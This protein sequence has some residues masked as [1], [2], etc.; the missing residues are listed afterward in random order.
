MQEF[1]GGSAVKFQFGLCPSPEVEAERPV[2]VRDE[3]T[4]FHS[5]LGATRTEG[6]QG[7]EFLLEVSPGSELSSVFAKDS[8]PLTFARDFPGLEKLGVVGLFLFP[9]VEYG[10]NPYSCDSHSLDLPFEAGF[11]VRGLGAKGTGAKKKERKKGCCKLF[12][13]MFRGMSINILRD[14]G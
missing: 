10:L 14:E 3:V 13:H 4:A 9:A 12:V 1:E 7:L 5:A 6:M 11:V 8:G 2:G